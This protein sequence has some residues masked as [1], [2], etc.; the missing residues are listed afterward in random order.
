MFLAFIY[1][2]NGL[3]FQNISLLVSSSHKRTL[4]HQDFMILLG[5]PRVHPH[6]LSPWQHQTTVNLLPPSNFPVCQSQYLCWFSYCTQPIKNRD[7][8]SARDYFDFASSPLKPEH[9]VVSLWQ[10]SLTNTVKVSNIFSDEI[11]KL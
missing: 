4:L 9:L 8:Q 2:A 1:S 10:R 3:A 6:G 7:M 11:G 5:K